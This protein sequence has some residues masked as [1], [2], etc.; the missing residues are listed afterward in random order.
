MTTATT[1]APTNIAFTVPGEPQGKGRARIV[2][3]GGFSRMATPAKTLAYEGL[4]AQLA[5]QAM[6]G[7]PL[8][9]GPVAMECEILFSPPRS[10]SKRARADMLA[11]VL[12]PTKKPDADNVLKAIWDGMNGVVWHDDVQAV[13]V[14]VL[15]R[16]AEVPGVLVRVARI[17]SSPVLELERAAA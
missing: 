3:I 7:H 15:K 9:E 17:C 4:V 6:G 10:A 11:G 12:R 2:R 13:D 16:Y 5:Q 8:I 14:R 1:Y